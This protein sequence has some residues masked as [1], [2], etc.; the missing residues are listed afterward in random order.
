[1]NDTLK[2][3]L[4]IQSAQNAQ[5]FSQ[6]RLAEV[7]EFSL[8]KVQSI[9]SKLESLDNVKN[10]GSRQ[11]PQYRLTS[12]GKQSILDSLSKHTR[13]QLPMSLRKSTF[14]TA[15]I[16]AAGHSTASDQP[17]ALSKIDENTILLL[18]NIQKLVDRGI[19]HIVIV[20][21]YQSE[22]IETALQ[23]TPDV[24]LVKV[25]DYEHAGTMSSLSQAGTQINDSFLLLEG[26]LL[27]DD[28]MLDVLLQ[29][30]TENTILV[31]P[32]SGS[33][34]EAFVDFN[35]QNQLI[36]ISKDIR[37]MNRLSAEMIGISKVS[38]A[39]YQ[40][41]LS[42]YM[43]N[44]NPWLNYE[45]LIA[46]LSNITPV[47][48]L[49]TDDLHWIDIDTPK[50][51]VKAI[52]DVFPLIKA[53]ESDNKI[54]QAKQTIV[55]ALNIPSQN[56]KNVVYAGG[57]TNTNYSAEIIQ[58]ENKG[59]RECFVR[60]PGKGTSKLINR[61]TEKP[62][63]EQ[64]SK[65]GF[66]VPTL[67]MD[68]TSGIKITETIPGAVT[69]SARSMRIPS[70]YHQV[71]RLLYQVHHSKMNFSNNFSFESEWSHYESAANDL[72]INY[73]DY[74]SDVKEE[75]RKANQYL[76]NTLGVK[77]LP[78]HNDLVPENFIKG[79]SS[80]RSEDSL[81]LI[82]WEYSGNNDPAW[83]LAA[84]INESELSRAE[85]DDFLAHYSNVSD[86]LLLKRKVL[87][88]KAFQD[89]LWSTWSLVKTA[90]GVDFSEY[91]KKRFERAR[92]ELS[93]VLAYV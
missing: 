26:D 32:L 85:E 28:A 6:R 80:S 5:S 63:A 18:R 21:G 13:I 24:T 75:V 72:S 76:K 88:Y 9:L 46:Q 89:V 8:T 3:L 59:W 40:L 83:D 47:N 19:K 4:L 10:L 70:N 77:S 91:G 27:F 41:M 42:A 60:I 93:Q 54:D 61:M 35:S 79:I 87:V 1:M 34:D 62:N 90:S 12:A 36:Q 86:N 48:C 22:L 73:Y 43:R 57:M 81:Y 30:T 25:K 17:V 66:N 69:F 58:G 78:C 44:K 29:D 45:Y 74:Y 82:D 15:V 50:D 65:L 31:S 11:K 71:A 49:V 64:A 84:L 2:I 7:S 20:C 52:Q 16:L 68:P 39:F 56:V 38:F 67:F 37:Q 14:T 33:H 51:L 55:N 23:D 53:N 92:K